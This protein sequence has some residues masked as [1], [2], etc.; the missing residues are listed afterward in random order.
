VQPLVE[1]QQPSCDLLAGGLVAVLLRDP[2]EGAEELE[3]RKEGDELSVR[4]PVSLADRD[5]VRAAG[6]REL[7]ADAALPD[8]RLSDHAHHLAR[9]RKRAREGRLERRE[10]LRPADEAQEA[11]RPRQVEA[12]AQAAHALE[13]VHADGLAHTLEREE[14]EVAQAE[15]ASCDPGCVV[16]QVDSPRLGELLHP[17]RQPHDGTLGRVVHPQIVADLLPGG[18]SRWHD[19]QVTGRAPPAGWTCRRRRSLLYQP[20]AAAAEP[21]SLGCARPAAAPIPWRTPS[22]AAAAGGSRSPRRRAPSPAPTPPGTWPRRS[23]NRRAL[24]RGSASR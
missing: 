9:A 21:G 7:V 15:E 14:A 2:V 22:A 1:E 10:L 8:A 5:A 19:G 13:L 4:D 16:T 12:A 18:F 3:D 11:A 6:L 17:G 20:S 24:S 23:S